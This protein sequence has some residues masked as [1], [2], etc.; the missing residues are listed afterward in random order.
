MQIETWIY[1][2]DEGFLT[3]NP[4]KIRGVFFEHFPE[5]IFDKT[6]FARTHLER[7][8]QNVKEQR[9]EPPEFIQKGF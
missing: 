1:Y 9:L 2:W 3:F 8:L 5:A 4:E 6:N 7:F